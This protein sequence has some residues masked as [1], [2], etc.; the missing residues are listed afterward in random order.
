VVREIVWQDVAKHSFESIQDYILAKW[1]ANA[2][3][4][5]TQRV[6]HFLE[7]LEK[8]PF[9]GT[10]ENY[11]AGIRGFTI[12]SQTKLLYKVTEEKIFLLAFYDL[13]QDPENK[14]KIIGA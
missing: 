12:S 7:I 3:E 5:F 10:V 11:N 2:V 4:K 13:R 6:F 8:F 1:G 9:I 14:S